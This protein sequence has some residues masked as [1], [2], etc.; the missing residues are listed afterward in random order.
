MLAPLKS[1]WMNEQSTALVLDCGSLNFRAGITGMNAQV[2]FQWNFSNT[3]D[4]QGIINVIFSLCTAQLKSRGKESSL[5]RMKRDML[6]IPFL[7]QSPP[8][9]IYQGMI[10]D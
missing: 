3:S 5:H 6:L 9:P 7:F 1:T 2:M 8:T 10:H 4:K